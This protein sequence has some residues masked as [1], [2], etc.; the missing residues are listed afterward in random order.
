MVKPTSDSSLEFG[1]QLDFVGAEYVWH[2]AT[3]GLLVLDSVSVKFLGPK[4]EINSK[5]SEMTVGYLKQL[6]KHDGDK[7]A[8]AV[9]AMEN[10]GRHL[11]AEQAERD[12]GVS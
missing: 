5:L 2:L 1:L 10:L 4:G 6:E 7:V 9:L 3:L 12:L 8:R 11:L